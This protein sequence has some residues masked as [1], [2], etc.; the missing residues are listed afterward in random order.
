MFDI[1]S[2]GFQPWVYP[3]SAGVLGKCLPISVPE[4][5][6]PVPGLN[7]GQMHSSADRLGMWSAP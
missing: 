2:S 1:K 5:L 6:V 7:R 3:L 4:S